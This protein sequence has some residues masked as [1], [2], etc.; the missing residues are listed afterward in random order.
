L[1]PHSPVEDLALWC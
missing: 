1:S